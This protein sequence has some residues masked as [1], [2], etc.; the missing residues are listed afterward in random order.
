MALSDEKIREYTKRLMMSRF[1]VLNRHGFF[2]LLL[3]HMKFSLDEHIETASTDGRYILFSPSFID[4]LSDFEIDFIMMH[5]VMHVVLKHCLRTG[6][7][8]HFLFN[9]ACDIVVN[10][11]IMHECGDEPASI[12][13]KK[14]GESMHLAPDGK[15]GHNYTAEQ[16]YEMLLKKFKNLPDTGKYDNGDDS[17]EGEDGS[18]NDAL[19]ELLKEIKKALGDT[20]DDHSKWGTAP[21]PEVIRD[22]I[23]NRI[24]Q[25]TKALEIR[26][27]STGM[28]GPPVFALRM[29]KELENPQI[30]WRT[31]LNEFV[32]EEVCDYSFAPPDRRYSD[33]GFFLPDFNELE[34]KVKNVW[35]VVDTSGSISDKE[36]TAAY[37]EIR[38]AIEQFGGALEGYLSFTEAYVT[39]PIP[40]SSVEDLMAIKPVGGGGNDFSDIFRYMKGNMMDDPP[41]Y[42]IIITDGYDAFPDESMALG[43]PVLWV[44]NNENRTPPW[45][46]VA[47][48]SP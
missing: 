35:F 47:R 20:F 46:K 7:R 14:Y 15:E 32:H 5:E 44:I 31:I 2:G 45:G 27:S 1:R 48:I 40:F 9:V 11:V 12:T 17:I 23:N 33:S 28:G 3:S 6:D 25:A 43:I 42:I 4:D 21:D 13:L 30:D 8:H 29:V 36:L 37:A 34:T 41:A 24:L 38:S 22:E 10:S 18:G 39:H 26:E 16:V 19:D